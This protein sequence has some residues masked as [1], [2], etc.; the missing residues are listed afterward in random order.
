MRAVALTVD[1]DVVVNASTV[2]VFASTALKPFQ[3]H[4]LECL[5]LSLLA[6][7]LE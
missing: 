1:V 7:R 3:T 6:A 2:D 4:A 5:R